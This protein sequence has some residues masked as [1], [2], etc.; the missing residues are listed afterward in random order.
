MRAGGPDLLA[1]DHPAPIRSLGAVALGAG[2]DAGH[3]R[4]GRRLGEELAPHFPPV[5]RRLHVALELVR[6]GVGH[7]GRDAHAEADVEEAQRHEIVRFLLLVDHLQDRRSPAPAILLGPGDAGIACLGL[8]ILPG[9]GLA[10]QLGIVAAG[11]K[12]LLVVALAGGVGVEPGAYFL[13]KGGFFGR[14]VEIHGRSLQA[15]F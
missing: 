8:F 10:Q 3:V 11:A 2:A 5:Q 7:H 9:L 1:I 4:A 12:A 15:A 6:R 14:I 13:A